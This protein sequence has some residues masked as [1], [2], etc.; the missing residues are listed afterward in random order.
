MAIVFENFLR[1]VPSNDLNRYGVSEIIRNVSFRRKNGQFD[2]GA[3]KSCQR[4]DITREISTPREPR[5]KV[6][7]LSKS[8]CIFKCQNITVGT[9]EVHGISD[10]KIPSVEFLYPVGIKVT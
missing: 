8:L 1:L 9:C 6:N 7:T 3:R 10:F 2:Y 5:V 4:G